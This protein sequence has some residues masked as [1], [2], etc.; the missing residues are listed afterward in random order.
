MKKRF[1]IIV[2]LVA[3][4]ISLFS[5]FVTTNSKPAKAK[6]QADI[7]SSIF[8]N[9]PAVRMQSGLILF[10]DSNAPDFSPHAVTPPKPNTDSGCISDEFVSLRR[11]GG[12]VE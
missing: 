10:S 2:A 3:L 7:S 11:Y 1:L 5:L 12:C 8:V 6:I 9:E 4:S